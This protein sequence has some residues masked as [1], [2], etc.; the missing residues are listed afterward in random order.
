[1]S[2]INYP[3]K[4]LYEVLMNPEQGRKYLKTALEHGN[5]QLFFFA[6]HHL[7]DAIVYDLEINPCLETEE[8]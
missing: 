1:M 4:S 8:Q 3:R 2:L 6:L 7:I 5:E